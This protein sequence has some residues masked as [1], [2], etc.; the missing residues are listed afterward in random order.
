MSKVVFVERTT[1]ATPSN[2]LRR[3][4]ASNSAWSWVC[5]LGNSKSLVPV[6]EMRSHIPAPI[7]SSSRTPTP[8]TAT[9]ATTEKVTTTGASTVTQIKRA[10]PI[11]SP[12]FIAAQ[13]DIAVGRFLSPPQWAGP[14]IPA[15]SLRPLIAATLP[16]HDTTDPMVPLSDQSI[17]ADGVATTEKGHRPERLPRAPFRDSE[18]DSRVNVR[19][20]VHKHD[21]PYHNSSGTPGAI[22]IRSIVTIGRIT[23][24]RGIGTQP[25]D[26]HCWTYM[27]SRPAVDVYR[28][29]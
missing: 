9:D 22:V 27:C 23:V 7:Q 13:A 4:S 18:E 20:S 28:L 16:E 26:V 19:T 10:A 11:P 14:R 25:I 29:I 3:R 5:S 24:T 15:A 8:T 21:L 12:H 6:A 1:S 17:V 2:A